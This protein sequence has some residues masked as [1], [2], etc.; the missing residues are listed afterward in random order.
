MNLILK[1]GDINNVRSEGREMGSKK[2]HISCE[3]QIRFYCLFDR[4]KI[5][6]GGEDGTRLLLVRATAVKYGA[7]WE[8]PPQR[9]R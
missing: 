3:N 7:G 2:I 6:S 5:R 9:D 1:H 8:G 4:R